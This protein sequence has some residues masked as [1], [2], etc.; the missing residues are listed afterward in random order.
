MKEKITTG[1]IQKLYQTV[2]K[3]QTAEDAEKLFRDLCSVSEILKMAQ[4]LRAAEL[5]MA[6]KTYAEVIAETDIS[7]TTL[8]R[9]SACIHNGA[10]GYLQFI[11]I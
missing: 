3:I 6:G 1:M 8:S 5:L 4:R 11:E 2:V 9:V 7:S 10:G